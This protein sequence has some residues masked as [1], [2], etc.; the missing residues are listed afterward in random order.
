V[1]AVNLLGFL[2][3]IFEPTPAVKITDPPDGGRV[4]YSHLVRGV[5]KDT[6]I[7]IELFVQAADGRW[8]LQAPTVRYHRHKFT[9][10]CM[11]GDPHGN[12]GHVYTLAAIIPVT[13]TIESPVD[14]LPDHTTSDSV[15][16]T[17]ID[18]DPAR[19]TGYHNP[20]PTGDGSLGDP[21]Q[22]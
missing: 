21:Q 22:R 14:A 7:D 9:G 17:R 5:A 16:V 8:Y 6:A 20:R 15:Q 11:F 18:F 4:P 3:R 10:Y 2:R 1:D 12:G 13:P 19:P